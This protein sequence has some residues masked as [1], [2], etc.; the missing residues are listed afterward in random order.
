MNEYKWII[1]LIN[2]IQENTSKI[3]ET[4]SQNRTA[5]W[6]VFK[7]IVR[8]S[9]LQNEINLKIDNPIHYHHTH[10]IIIIAEVQVLEKKK[11]NNSTRMV[12]INSYCASGMNDTHVF[13]RQEGCFGNL[14]ACLMRG[15]YVEK[16]GGRK[17]IVRL[18]E[19]HPNLP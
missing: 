18:S 8:L 17:I 3:F 6:L 14:L 4:C 13:R 11:A 9:C 15:S 19:L 2:T 7:I 16:G 12:I 1:R 5:R 10:V